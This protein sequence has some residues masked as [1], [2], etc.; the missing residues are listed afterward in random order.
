[1]LSLGGDRRGGDHLPGGCVRRAAGRGADVGAASRD[2][3]I[4]A[5]T[6]AN[7]A[8]SPI[9]ISGPD[10]SDTPKQNATSAAPV[11]CPSRRDTATIPLA[12]PA[13][14]SEEHTSEL[15]S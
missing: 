6:A 9:A 2:A 10:R 15:Q 5:E 1:R 11:V 7:P 14:R 4:T 12:P 13:R 8:P 3:L